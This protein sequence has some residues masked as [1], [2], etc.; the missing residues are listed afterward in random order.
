MVADETGLEL[1][2]G[3]SGQGEAFQPW[4]D[5]QKVN[6]DRRSKEHRIA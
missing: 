4:Y 3:G 6:P 5:F 1:L 2:V